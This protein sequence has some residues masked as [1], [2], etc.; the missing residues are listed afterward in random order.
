MRKIKNNVMMLI[1]VLPIVAYL[2][3]IFKTGTF[4]NFYDT[5]VNTFGDFGSFFYPII[6]PLLQGFVEI[7][8]SNGISLLGWFIGY[9]VALLFTLLLFELFTF[10]ITFFMNKIDNIKGG[11]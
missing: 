4:P 1:A 11:A 6:T 8:D 7:A 9:Y 3:S 2:L 5:V 10:V